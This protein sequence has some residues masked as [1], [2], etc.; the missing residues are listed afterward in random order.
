MNQAPGSQR[1]ASKREDPPRAAVS[2]PSSPTCSLHTSL[3][4]CKLFPF[5]WPAEK[6]PGGNTRN[7]LGVPRGDDLLPLLTERP[8]VPGGGGAQSSP[9]C[10][11][12][13]PK[14][15]PDPR[16]KSVTA[17]PSLEA[18]LSRGPLASDT[19]HLWGIWKDGV[20]QRV[21][22]ERSELLARF[23]TLGCLL[24]GA[25]PS[26]EFS[27]FSKMSSRSH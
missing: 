7:E 27:K 9:A 3:Q 23:H 14:S 18:R 21:L 5:M 19:L 11:D 22:T 4:L 17:S 1:A 2:P 13:K 20:P 12:L 24:S 25:N 26:V 8:R 6:T 15:S 16:L 10:G